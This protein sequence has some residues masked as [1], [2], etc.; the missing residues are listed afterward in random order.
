MNFMFQADAVAADA[1]PILDSGGFAARRRGG[2]PKVLATGLI[3]G[4]GLVEILALT[5]E[6]GTNIGQRFLYSSFF[7]A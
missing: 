5:G 2:T 4:V 7:W 1:I 3:I 6:C